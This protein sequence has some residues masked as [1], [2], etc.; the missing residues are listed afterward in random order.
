MK[1]D[2]SISWVPRKLENLSKLNVTVVG[3]T[4]GLGRAI[5]K[6][7]AGAGAK[8]IVIGQ[9]FRD[10]DTKNISFVKADLSSI[11]KSREVAKTLDVSDT[12]ILLFTTGIIAARK[13]EETEEGLE[14]DM[15]VSFL[16]R[17]VMLREI[18][19]KLKSTRFF[20]S[21]PRVFVMAFPGNDQLG[22]IDDLNC[23]KKY[24]VMQAHMNTVAGNEALV[25]DS[26]A[27]Y[28][29]LRFY[30]LNPGLVKTAI[31]NNVLGEGSVLSTVVEGMVGWFANSPEQYAQKI[32][33]LLIAEEL[34]E[35]NG[36][37]FN[38]K[39]QALHPSKDLTTEYAGKFISAAEDLLKSKNL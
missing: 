8:V 7:F 9:T 32:A 2:K 12:D 13:R 17:I 6:T 31:R 19:P 3:G 1:V 33:P 18:A 4:G 37:I 16:N 24:G 5:S 10:A 21:S 26:V 30:G 11:E 39:G 15:A 36:A 22:T 20:A 34:D 23:E 14:R 35:N 27:K 25:Y 38:N 28:K 29:D